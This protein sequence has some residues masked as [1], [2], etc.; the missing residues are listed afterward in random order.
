MNVH[1]SPL[2]TFIRIALN[3]PKDDGN[4]EK[5]MSVDADGI[6]TFRTLVR[7]VLRTHDAI[8]AESARI[9]DH[10][11]RETTLSP[12]SP[13]EV[14]LGLFQSSTLNAILD[15]MQWPPEQNI[16]DQSL[17]L[18]S[19]FHEVNENWGVLFSSLTSDLLIERKCF[20]STQLTDMLRNMLNK[21]LICHRLK[22]S[23]PLLAHITR[24]Y[25][26][27][28]FCIRQKLF[29]I[30]MYFN[31]KD[32]LENSESFIIPRKN[33]LEFVTQNLGKMIDL[34][35]STWK[36]K[37]EKEVGTGRGPAKEFFAEF[38]R[39]CE[40]YDSHI[41]IGEPIIDS[42]GV[43]YSYSPCGLFFSP[44]PLC[45]SESELKLEALG[46]IMGKSLLD[47]HIMDINLS[48]AF[49]K[50]IKGYSP[51]GQALTLID[52][53]DIM[54]FFYEFIVKLVDVLRM[55]NAIEND[56]S[57]TGEESSR[58]ISEIMIDGASFDDLCINFTLPGYPEIEMKEGGYD[59]LLTI[60]NLEE[61]L[62][63]LTW[64]LLYKGPLEKIQALKQH[65][66][67]LIPTKRLEMFYPEEIDQLFCGI[68]S[69]Q[70]SVA[71]L[72]ENCI[73]EDDLTMD[74]PVVQYLFEVLSSFSASEQRQFLQFVTSTPRLPHGGLKSLLPSLTIK[75]EAF[76]G[77]PDMRLPYS[78][79]CFNMLVVT[80]YS[81]K[82][83]LR[84]KLLLA[85]TEGVDSFQYA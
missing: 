49:Y 20:I 1:Y 85:I 74:S 84:E 78:R 37:F 59:T 79:T 47:G 11:I 9:S 14:S 81:S 19:I 34:K 42:N 31:P 30:S 61:Y 4:H 53:K 60:E 13:K 21:K 27:V 26:L 18:L 71:Y 54:P 41:W 7:F 65:L 10:S 75:C 80:R 43:L 55:K 17:R 12:Q 58:M 50:C 51:S 57:L 39:D 5:R 46:F 44:K 83:A 8:Q 66:C 36:L 35:E 2:I 69:E 38:S 82:D 28:P 73:L 68:K 33:T 77:D 32:M 56:Q 6:E 64:W 52:I 62:Q 72:N 67:E 70:W 16:V 3:L 76:D 22:P 48:K 40:R 15:P 29:K 25:F 45:A 63:L 24:Y 23:R